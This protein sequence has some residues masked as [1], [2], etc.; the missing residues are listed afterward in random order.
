MKNQNGKASTVLI[1]ILLVVA[2]VLGLVA[3]KF[4]T[5]KNEAT[6][7][8]QKLETEV[9]SLNSKVDSLQNTINKVSDVISSTSNSTS[10]V[11]NKD[12]TVKDDEYK[13][14][15]DKLDGI[16]VLYVTDAIDNGDTYTLKGVI[17]T[18]Y[19]FTEDEYKDIKSKAKYTIDGEEYTVKEENNALAL[20]RNGEESPLHVIKKL[21]DGIYYL[22][23]QAQI[24]DNWKLTKDYRKITVSKDTELSMEF[25]DDVNTVEKR[26]KDFKKVEP[27]ETTNPLSDYTFN[28]EFKDGKCVKVVSTLTSI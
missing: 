10:N 27:Q 3:Y 19:T 18:R 5:E 21:N 24:S 7:K 6:E 12:T 20:Y 25:N 16:D 14:I 26:F 13:E 22:E 9:A 4:Y 28:F 1:V 2:V 17:Y 11:I 15:D 23:T 8:A